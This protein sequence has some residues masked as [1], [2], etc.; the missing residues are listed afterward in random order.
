MAT[1]SFDNKFIIEDGESLHQ[2]V[3]DL[4]SPENIGEVPEEQLE[5]FQKW[6]VELEIV[7]RGFHYYD[8]NLGSSTGYDCWYGYFESSYTPLEALKEDANHY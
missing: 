4:C 1:S 6:C 3:R 7:N 8:G 2:F 5:A